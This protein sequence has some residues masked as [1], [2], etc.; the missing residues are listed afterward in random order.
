[1]RYLFYI[2]L[3]AALRCGAA[4]AESGTSLDVQGT[5]FVVTLSDG[6]LRR[7]R[8]L[9]GAK[10]HMPDGN[11]LRIN[12]VER[13]ML[14]DGSVIWLHSLSIQ[15]NVGWQPVCQPDSSG[16]SLGFPFPGAFLQDGRYVPGKGLFSLS[17]TSGA[18]AKCIR[19]GYAPWQK[20][21]N[22][23]S[24]MDH[25]NACIRMVRA[26][27]CGD[28][29]ANTVNGTAIDVYDDVGVQE[30]DQSIAEMGFEAGWTPDGAVCVSHV[31]VPTRPDPRREGPSCPRLETKPQGEACTEEW[32]R[33]HGAILFN[34]SR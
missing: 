1:M 7:S 25:Y 22:G 26:D 24:L 14:S 15:T 16:R 5:E 19:F 27:Y 21:P 32:A 17:C 2:A 33:K 6:T 12:T 23:S 29:K 10:L 13:E 30:S 11:L 18:Q 4:L 20:E 9:V 8:E 28:Q 31:R 3:V 34:R